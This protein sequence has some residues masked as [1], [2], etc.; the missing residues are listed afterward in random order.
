M[1]DLLAIL[2]DGGASLSAHRAAAA[3]ASHNLQNAN[4]PGFARQ[5]A[6]LAAALPARDLGTGQV[7]RGV[8]LTGI[9]QARDR[10]LER[11]MPA[12]ITSQAQSTA[13]ADVLESLNALDPV[14]GAGISSAL[15]GFYSAL[16]ALSQNP[17]DIG[18]RVAA[19]AA[20]RTLAM[21]FNRTA[22]QIEGSRSAVDAKLEGVL[23]E[24]NDAAVAVAR[25]NKDIKA[26]RTTGSEP[27]DLLDARLRHLDR[28]AELTGATVVPNANGDVNVVLPGGVSLVSGQ[29]AAEFSVIADTSNDGHAAIQLRPTDGTSAVRVP[30]AALAGAAGGLVAARDGALAAAGDSLDQ[31]AFDLAGA[32]N[33]TH[34]AGFDLDGGTNNDFF[35]PPAAAQGAAAALSV[36]AALLA[37]PRRLASAA[38]ANA[39]GDATN[40]NALIST[41]RLGL[42]TGSD[43]GQTLAR[44]T[45]AYGAQTSRARATSDQDGAI[46]NHLSGLR[47]SVS[48]VSIDEELVNLTKSQRAYEAV[49]KVITTAD[50]MLETLLNLK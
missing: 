40:V 17:G 45:A 25:L 15:G 35:A 1:S 10:F 22:V 23:Q 24:A 49:M 37:D 43:A 29:R 12:A 41:E 39:P 46:L 21:A 6:D 27:N 47:E 18:L 3:T 7:G 2:T 42:S 34:R 9:S 14:S 30:A 4:T 8:V 33:T 13:E 5:R 48:G 20:G 38:A 16:R 19:T 11:Q 44:L 50:G 32:I 31:L 26:A 36:D 28:L